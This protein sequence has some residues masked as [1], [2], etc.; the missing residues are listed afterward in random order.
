MIAFLF[1]IAVMGVVFTF[2]GIISAL[3]WFANTAE[4]ECAKRRGKYTLRRD[5]DAAHTF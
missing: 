4:E 1:V 3:V 5:E 2:T